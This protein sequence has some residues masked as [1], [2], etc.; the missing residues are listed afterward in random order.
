MHACEYGRKFFGIAFCDRTNGSLIF[1]CGVFDEVELVFAA[2]FI[3]GVAGAH[4]F[5]FDSSTYVTGHKFVDRGLNLAAYA[6]YLSDAL[7]VAS[8]DV[9]EVDTG[10]QSS[11]HH[12]EVA[13]LANV[14]FD[15]CLKH[16]D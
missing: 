6:I 1:G 2:F 14:R 12:F 9:V 4:I 5:E 8:G 11:G 16:E 10:F 13:Y 3:E 7:F 15:G